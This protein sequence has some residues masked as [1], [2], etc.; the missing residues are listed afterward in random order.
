MK[1][2]FILWSV[3]VGDSVRLTNGPINIAGAVVSNQGF[4]QLKFGMQMARYYIPNRNIMV[5]NIFRA[6]ICPGFDCIQISA[7]TDLDNIGSCD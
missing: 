3:W 4:E 5:V 1:A 6:E 7:Q 2:S